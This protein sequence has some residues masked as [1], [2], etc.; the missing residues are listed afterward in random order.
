LLRRA[1]FVVNDVPEAHFCCGSAG[2]YNLLQPDIA[3]DLGTR[4]AGHIASTAPQIVAAGNIGCLT[5]IALYSDVPIVHT[6]EL[7][8]WAYG[9]PRPHALAGVA[10]TCLPEDTALHDEAP[11]AAGALEHPVTFQRPVAPPPPPA[12]IGLW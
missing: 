6:V 2:T 12:D 10:L 3:R 1:G 8:D 7:L 5:Q 4:K 9:G 11:T